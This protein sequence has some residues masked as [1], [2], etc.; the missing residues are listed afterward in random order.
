MDLQMPRLSGVGAIQALREQWSE[1]RAL[2]LTTFAQ[3][4]HLFEA[5][6]AGARGYLL[7]D[8]G[9]E[10]L[11]AAIK[12]VHEGGSLV[13]PVMASR[14]LD[15]FGELATRERLPEGLTERELEVL[16]L[17]ASGA[18]N[19]EIAERLALLWRHVVRAAQRRCW[20]PKA[21]RF[22]TCQ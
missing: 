7:K 16:R 15:R 22:G 8:A 11:A 19:R 9:P 14:L 20:L 5:L 1:A 6:R 17:A 13:Q 2:I 10:E 21:W 4:E 3:D 18:R 12:T